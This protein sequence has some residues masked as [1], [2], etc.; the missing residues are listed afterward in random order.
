MR[1]VQETN[2]GGVR[3]DWTHSSLSGKQNVRGGQQVLVA[4]SG[5]VEQCLTNNEG[6][7]TT[8][9]V[10][11][12]MRL[13]FKMRLDRPL[14]FCQFVPSSCSESAFAQP[15]WNNE[16]L[17]QDKKSLGIEYSLLFPSV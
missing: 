11:S 6:V 5:R 10:I 4:S 8:N 9:R 3:N 7:T 14:G 12:K 16:R 1:S 17:Q 2:N 15:L 13:S